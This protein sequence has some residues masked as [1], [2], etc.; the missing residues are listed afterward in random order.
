MGSDNI[1]II[2]NIAN[3]TITLVWSPSNMSIYKRDI[4]VP[5][6]STIEEALTMAR[7]KNIDLPADW[8]TAK[9]G[10][11]G[12]HK[13]RDTVLRDKDRIEIHRALIADPKEARRLRAKKNPL[14]APKINTKKAA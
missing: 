10:I 6:G 9:L 14:K 1:T 4:E 13:P 5:S 11:Y 2:T 8:Q 3:I 12:K 7:L